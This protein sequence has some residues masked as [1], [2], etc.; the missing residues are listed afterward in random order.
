MVE[1]AQTINEAQKPPRNLGRGQRRLRNYFIN[2]R[3]QL[4]FTLTIVGVSSVIMGGLSF[5]VMS[6]AHEA[7]RI[8][9]V[10]AL[11]DDDLV[12]HQLV[13][14]FARN[15]RVLTMA[16]L[17]CGLLLAVVLFAYGIVLTHKVAG[18]LFKVSTHLDRIRDGRLGIVYNLRKGDELVDFFERFKAAHDALRARTVEDIRLLD[19]TIAAIAVDKSPLVDELKRVRD[20][21]AQSLR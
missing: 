17:A 15:D 3:Y 18:P 16:L 10:R 20:E 6:K 5:I 19:Q 9:E 4:K 7:S 14:Q 13:E 12:A 1:S 21:K 11:D 2:L 8:I